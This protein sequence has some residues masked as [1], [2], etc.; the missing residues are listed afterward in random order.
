M[1]ND[2]LIRCPN[3]KGSV[4]RGGRGA[5]CCHKCGKV[6]DNYDSWV[7]AVRLGREAGARAAQRLEEANANARYPKR[8][9]KGDVVEARVFCDYLGTVKVDG[10]TLARVQFRGNCDGTD[11]VFYVAP[12]AVEVFMRPEKEKRN[13]DNR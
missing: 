5:A 13:A 11:P 7:E 3:C 1:P 6:G 4:Y 9:R 2:T 10:D 12:S 8:P